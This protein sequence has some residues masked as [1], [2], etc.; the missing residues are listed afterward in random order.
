MD[1]KDVL[2]IKVDPI[3]M[4]AWNQVQKNWDSISKPLDGMGHFEPVFDRIGAILGTDDI[5]ISKKAVI[6]MCA[7][8]GVVAEGISQS[9]Q[10]ITLAVAKRMAL[11]DTAV[12]KMASIIGA[13]TFPVDVGIN[14][15]EDVDGLL[16]K[17]VRKGTRNFMLEP[18]IAEEEVVKAIFTG[19]DMVKDCASKGYK[20]VA[21]GEMGIG[22]TTT[23]SAIA[24]AVLKCSVEE[25]TGRGAG[26]SDAGLIR[27]QRVIKTAI[28][29]YHLYEADAFDVLRCVGGLDIAGLTGVCIGGA[30]YHIP[31]VLDG[32][33]S[34]VA[35]LLAKALVPGCESYLFASHWGKEPAVTRLT[36][37][38][39]LNALVDG[40]L[41][42]G[43]GT[44][45]VMMMGL[46]DMAMAVY[47][48][49]VTFKDV[50]IQQYTRFV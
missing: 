20:M 2:S 23:S 25:V 32:V 3:N 14:C 50:N 33:I 24:A 16:N 10:E 47:N 31:V 5:D 37:A 42:L 11:E 4:D 29:K 34:L 45:A 35:A 15:D 18:A 21:T 46:L 1:R 48:E 13:K 36:Q 49:R 26:L 27:K 28:E 44:G 6:I 38:L 40:N 9:G 12:G 22:N 39:G 17:K 43:E 19:I 7:D 8:N 41:A 30:I